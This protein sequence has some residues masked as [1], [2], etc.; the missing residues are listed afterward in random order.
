MTTILLVGTLTT[1]SNET[2]PLQPVGVNQIQG[3]DH[4]RS[5]LNQSQENRNE[6]IDIASPGVA[7]NT[8]TN[9]SSKYYSH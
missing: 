4:L 5:L 9:D 6:F 8:T 2:I 3:E 1:R 7:E